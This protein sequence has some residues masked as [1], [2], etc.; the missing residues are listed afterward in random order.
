MGSLG[1]FSYFDNDDTMHSTPI[2]PELMFRLGKPSVLYGQADFCYGAENVMG[3]YTSRLGVGSG[4][5][6]SNGSRLLLG[7]AHSPHQPSP[8]MGF[9]SALLR[10]PGATGLTLE[11]YYATDLGRHNSL[12]LKLNYRIGR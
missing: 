7:Y 5:G 9:V 1:Y 12:S 3:A 2:M 8:S 6:T 10:M 11:P 4:L